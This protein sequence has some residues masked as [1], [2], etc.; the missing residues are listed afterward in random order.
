MVCFV[1]QVVRPTPTQSHV[2]HFVAPSIVQT[3]PSDRNGRQFDQAGRLIRA[4]QS[5]HMVCGNAGWINGEL[6]LFAAE[7]RQ[8]LYREHERKRGLGVCVAEYSHS[9]CDNVIPQE[10][11]MH[12]CQLHDAHRDIHAMDSIKR[13]NVGSSAIQS[14]PYLHYSSS[15]SSNALASWRSAVSKPAVN[16]P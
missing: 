14:G 10:T 11:G 2:P 3:Q 16:K 1:N 6:S 9:R 8:V 7:A 12:R 15:S 13:E 5:A 4:L